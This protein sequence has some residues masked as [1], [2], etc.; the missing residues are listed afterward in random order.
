[1]Q[2]VLITG[3]CGT[4]GKAIMITAR[5]DGWKTQFTLL[6]RNELLQA[7]TRAQFPE[8]RYV[9]GDV[10]DYDRLNAVVAGHD[11]II[12]AA[13][14]KRIPE[15]EQSPTECYLTNVLGSANVIRAAIAQGVERVLGIS[16]DKACRATTAYGASKLLME[17]LFR[18]APLAPTV[19]TCVRYGNVM[20]SRGSVLELWARQAAQFQPLT[21]TNPH[22][23]RFF[24]SPFEAV[25][26]IELGLTMPHGTVTVK[27]M[28]SVSM[29]ELA[30]LL[31]HG[32]E[33]V[34]VGL[35]SEEKAHEDLIHADEEAKIYGSDHYIVGSGKTGFAYDSHSA[36]RLNAIEL[37]AMLDAA[38]ELE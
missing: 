9:I 7:Q 28:G 25:K 22:M 24:M 10:R 20:A 12:H 16:T 32:S 26:L 17:K 8:A 15:C 34:T 30:S 3:G 2:N 29:G 18:A 35:R 27:K 6:S 4:L 33:T 11:T 37:R 14:M 21:I 1:M 31:F 5:R 13:A 23:T 19:F 36:W 38:K